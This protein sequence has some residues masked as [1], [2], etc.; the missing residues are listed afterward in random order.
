MENIQYICSHNKIMRE[1][2][3]MSLVAQNHIKNNWIKR[4]KLYALRYLISI[5]Q[6]IRIT[7]N[8]LFTIEVCIYIYIYIYI[9][10]FSIIFIIS[11]ILF[12]SFLSSFVL[13]F[14][15]FLFSDP[16]NKL[17]ILTRILEGL[18]EPRYYRTPWLNALT[19]WLLGEA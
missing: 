19:L 3:I 13:L 14:S 4:K 15:F 16:P 9:Q 12:V 7:F 2:N 11:I 18:S 6:H 8:T 5:I 1:Y 17:L 10:V